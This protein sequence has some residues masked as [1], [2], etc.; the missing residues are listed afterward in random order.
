M[1][2]TCRS[3]I[4]RKTYSLIIFGKIEWLYVFYL[5]T[6]FICLAVNC[7]N[8]PDPANGNVTTLGGTTFE[9]LAVYRCNEGYV[10]SYPAGRTCLSSGLWSGTAPRCVPE[11]VCGKHGK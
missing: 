7:G 6:T 1:E 3:L 10:L 8:L 2:I 4:L 9:S 11:Q 5:L